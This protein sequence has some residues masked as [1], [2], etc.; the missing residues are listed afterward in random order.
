MH[1]F[2]TPEYQKLFI[3]HFASSSENKI[4][5]PFEVLPNHKAVLIGMK[6]VLGGQEITDYG[7]V[8]DPS[9]VGLHR[10]V[11]DLISTDPSIQTVQFDYVPHDSVLYNTLM[12]T[13]NHTKRI[14]EVAPH[15]TLPAQYEDYLSSLDRTDRKEIKRKLKRLDTVPHTFKVVSLTLQN[16]GDTMEQFET[17]IALHRISGTDK[18]NFMSEQMHTFFRNLAYLSIPGW[19]QNLAILTVKSRPAAALFFFANQ[20]AIL[21]YNSGFDPQ[22]KFYSVGLLANVQLIQYAIDRHMKVFDFMRGNERYKYELGGKDQELY[23][24]TL[25]L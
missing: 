20:D 23:Q 21:L 5:G 4:C 25:S 17:F 15:L 9:P 18:H 24:I 3:H 14:Q 13:P 2:Q 10:V 16:R 6:P 7:S 8:D 1:P 11:D 12:Q 19:T 22:F